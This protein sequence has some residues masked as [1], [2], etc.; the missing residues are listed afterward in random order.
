MSKVALGL[1]SSLPWVAG[2]LLVALTASAASQA[3]RRGTVVTVGST[4]LARKPRRGRS[5][6]TPAA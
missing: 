4:D 3:A 6:S 1:S 5:S 2:A